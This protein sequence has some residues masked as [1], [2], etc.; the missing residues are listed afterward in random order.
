M[1]WG[2]IAGMQAA[3]AG[4][5]EEESGAAPTLS[6]AAGS[7]AKAH[8]TLPLRLDTRLAP[9]ETTATASSPKSS[10]VSAQSPSPMG[11]AATAAAAASLHQ[12]GQGQA[13][14]AVPAG[15]GVA[16]GASSDAQARGLG[17]TAAQD[18]H[19]AG[20]KITMVSL[21]CGLG[22]HSALP[23]TRERAR[24]I[25]AWLHACAFPRGVTAARGLLDLV[26]LQGVHTEVAQEELIKG[27]SRSLD[28]RHLLT[29]V[30]TRSMGC[31]SSCR[32][33]HLVAA[34]S[35]SSF[36]Q[37]GGMCRRSGANCAIVLAA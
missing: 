37:L 5:S 17:R 18:E 26:V 27:I 14:Q 4:R 21:D 13:S 31:G 23:C 1:L 35:V 34:M 10:P 33:S 20:T 30:G 28:L 25:A 19:G 29:A 8:S 12:S 24:H 11:A 9:E 36:S 7:S 32:L 2:A 16:G 15:G 6:N 3:G 22:V